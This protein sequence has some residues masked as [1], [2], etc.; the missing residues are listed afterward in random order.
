[1]RGFI[2]AALDRAETVL[3][4]HHEQLSR[5]QMREGLLRSIAAED[6][7]PDQATAKRALEIMDFIARIGGP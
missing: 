6:G 3:A 2:K 4:D 1:M 7:N 5:Y